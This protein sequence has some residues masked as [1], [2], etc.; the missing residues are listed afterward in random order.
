MNISD[1]ITIA[2]D[3]MRELYGID[4][5]RNAAE[6]KSLMEWIHTDICH[7]MVDADEVERV[8]SE[9]IGG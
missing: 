6:R 3:R 5:P 4:Y 8:V 2:V 9:I 1:K 7:C